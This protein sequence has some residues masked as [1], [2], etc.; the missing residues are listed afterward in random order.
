MQANTSPFS[1]AQSNALS[2]FT[3]AQTNAI[4]TQL[5]IMRQGKF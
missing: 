3:N 4:S 5:Q 1:N 2:T